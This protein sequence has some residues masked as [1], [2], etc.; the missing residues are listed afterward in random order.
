ME[1]RATQILEEEHHLIQQIVG[2]M[3]ALADQVS[4]GE[5]VERE[6]LVSVAEFMQIFVGKCHHEKEERYL[7]P[8]LA[9]KG[10]PVA[11]CP[12]GALTHEHESAAKLTADLGAAVEA[13]LK[14]PQAMKLFLTTTLR[15]IVQLYPSHIWKENYLLFPMTDKLLD[16]REQQELVEQFER[17]ERDIGPDVHHR[18]EDLAEKLAARAQKA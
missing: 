13:Y 2:A 9:K 6:M 4:M 8:L 10:V 15:G 12:I 16:D 7:F 11:G 17:V 3:A 5:T 1:K 18:F 14:D